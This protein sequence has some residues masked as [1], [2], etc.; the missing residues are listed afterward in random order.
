VK[1]LLI[2]G[3][4]TAGTM[5]AYKMRRRLDPAA[6]EITIVDP[7]PIHYYQPGF[8]FVPFGV[9]ESHEL[10]RQKTEFLPAGVT[11]R[12]ETVEVVEPDKKRVKLQGRTEYLSYDVLIVATGT[13]IQ[14]GETEGLLGEGWR[15]DIFDFYSFDGSA[16]LRKKLQHF[17]GGRVVLNVAEMPIKC[18]VAPLEFLFLADYYFHTQGLRDKVELVYATPLDAAFTKPRAAELLGGLLEQKGVKVVPDFNLSEVKAGEKKIASYDGKELDYDLFVS[19]PV[20]MGDALWERSGLGDELNYVATDK[21]TLAAKQMKDVFVLGDATDLPSSK[22]GSVAHFEAD[23]LTEN[24]MRQIEGQALLPSFDGHANCFIE[25]GFGKGLLIDFNYTTEPLPGKF[26][27]PGVGPF[28][29]LAESKMNHWGKMMF[30]YVYWNQLIRGAEL[31]FEAQMVMAGK[32][33][34]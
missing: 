23:V 13:Q 30:R 32:R 22:A 29:L 26:P 12:A 3:A 34:A 31:P 18:P 8:L 2:L 4:G 9:Y 33:A 1:T 14:P 17:E 15:K 28:S 10:K 21:H 19:I 6:W 5:M 24:I 7:D 25:S 27:L 20:N 11:L 16:A